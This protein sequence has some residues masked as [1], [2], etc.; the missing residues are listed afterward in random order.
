MIMLDCDNQHQDHLHHDHNQQ[1]DHNITRWNPRRAN[2]A[3]EW[4]WSWTS[5]ACPKNDRKTGDHHDHHFIMVGHVD[6]VD[7]Y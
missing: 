3:N 7:H 6:H 5:A 4:L 1:N 2:G